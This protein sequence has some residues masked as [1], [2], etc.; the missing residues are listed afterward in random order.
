[1]S[2]KATSTDVPML[3]ECHLGSNS[4]SAFLVWHRTFFS[5]YTWPPGGGH[6]IMTSADFT[7]ISSAPGQY[8]Q[9]CDHA[10]SAEPCG[11]PWGRANDHTAQPAAVAISSEC[12][13]WMHAPPSAAASPLRASVWH[14][15]LV[16]LARCRGAWAG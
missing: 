10:L 12:L 8:I 16:M 1:M 6:P 14:A 3:I 13:T 7:S 5:V 9:T 2:Y 15:R 4:A 11:L